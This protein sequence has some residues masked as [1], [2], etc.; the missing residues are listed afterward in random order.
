[1]FRRFTALL[2]AQKIERRK[3]ISVN[4]ELDRRWKETAVS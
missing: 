4:N 2:I 1:M 3:K